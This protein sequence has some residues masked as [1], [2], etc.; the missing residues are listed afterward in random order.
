MSACADNPVHARLMPLMMLMLMSSGIVAFFFLDEN[1][2]I[3][4]T[5][6]VLRAPLL[7]FQT[8]LCKVFFKSCNIASYKRTG[9]RRHEP[10]KVLK[11]QQPSLW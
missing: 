6:W 5:R 8:V 4:F 11:A 1:H 7:G 10:P 9:C 3:T 2:C